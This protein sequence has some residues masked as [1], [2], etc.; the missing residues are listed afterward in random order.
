M[1]A[2]GHNIRHVD[3]GGG[4][5]I[6]YRTDNTPP[7]PPVAYAQ[8]VAKHIKPLGLKTVFEPGRL[9]VGNA[10]L[11]VT[12]V[13]FVKE[14]DAKNFV[15]VD[16]AMNDLIRPTLYDAFHD[17]RPVIMPNDNAPRIR[18]DFVGPVCETGD[19]SG[20]RPRGGKARP[21]DLI[22]ICT[23][24]AY[25]AVLSST[26]NSRLLIPEVLV[27]GERY[28]VV[29]PRRT[30]EELLALDSVPDWL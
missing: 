18:A 6:P 8:I 15:I 22:A 21:G 17:I 20:P 3:V 13:I 7:P 30:Y 27:D 28:H 14:G 26:Y 9:I 12:E 2:D 23:T 29:R 19:S 11:L 10:G 5:G 24:G 16:A 4:L 1:Q 25:G